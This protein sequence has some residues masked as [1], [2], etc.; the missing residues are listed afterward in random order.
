MYQLPM[1]LLSTKKILG[2]VGLYLMGIAAT[3]ASVVTE[4]INYFDQMH[5]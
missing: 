3:T 4:V 1:R 2:L 5:S